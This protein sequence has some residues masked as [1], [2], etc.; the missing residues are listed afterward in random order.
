MHEF[1]ISRMLCH[2]VNK[3]NIPKAKQALP[4][5]LKAVSNFMAWVSP[6]N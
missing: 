3:P 4:I 2:E 1:C 6:N 5:I